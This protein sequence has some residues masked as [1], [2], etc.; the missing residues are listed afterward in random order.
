MSKKIIITLFAITLLVTSLVTPICADGAAETHFRLNPEEEMMAV[1]PGNEIQWNNVSSARVTLV[2]TNT[3]KAD[4]SIRI[5]GRAGTTFSNGTVKLEKI[6]GNTTT[7]IATWRNLSSSSTTFTFNNDSVAV[8]SGTYKVS[9][10]IYAV[11]NGVSEKIETS[12]T[13]TY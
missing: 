10:T 3:G 9:I 2:F 8:T 6:N 1:I 11:R 5:S 13:S 4:I 12:K 7:T